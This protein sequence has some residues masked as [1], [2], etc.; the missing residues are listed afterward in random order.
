[1][2]SLVYILCALTSAACAAMLLRGYLR[3]RTR[4]LLWSGLCFAALFLNNLMLMMDRV[5]ITDRVLFQ[6]EWRTAVAVLGLAMLVYGLI[7][8][9]E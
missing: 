6:P 1:M 3:S 8:D 2:A 9:A 5:V 7:W 4:F